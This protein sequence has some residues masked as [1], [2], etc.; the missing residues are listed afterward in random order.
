MDTVQTLAQQTNLAT[1]LGLHLV[2]Y[3][4]HGIYGKLIA[5]QKGLSLFGSLA[6]CPVYNLPI[7]F[8]GI[9]AYNYHESNAPIKT[10]SKRTCRQVT[11]L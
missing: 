3:G 7:Y 4:C 9:W 11:C 10:A 6:S 2:N 1:L 5:F 8:F